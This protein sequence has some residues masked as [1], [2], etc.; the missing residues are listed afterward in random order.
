MAAVMAVVLV[1]IMLGD[2]AEYMTGVIP[3]WVRIVLAVWVVWAVNLAAYMVAKTAD[4]HCGCVGSTELTTFLTVQ[5]TKEIDFKFWLKLFFDTLSTYEKMEYHAQLLYWQFEKF[6]PS[7]LHIFIYVSFKEHD[8]NNN[9]IYV[10]WT[11]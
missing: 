4:F 7:W 5:C 8:V 6:L 11:L 2:T 3:D 10:L 1:V 9:I